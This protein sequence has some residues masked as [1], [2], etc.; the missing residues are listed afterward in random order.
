M[1]SKPKVIR[2]KCQNEVVDFDRRDWF[3]A[4]LMPVYGPFVAPIAPLLPVYCAFCCPFAPLIFWPLYGPYMA[5]IWPLWLLCGPYGP[6]DLQMVSSPLQKKRD[7][8]LNCIT[9]C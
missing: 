6:I 4:P 8:I 5:P 2:Y 1:R 9:P 3:I 7:A